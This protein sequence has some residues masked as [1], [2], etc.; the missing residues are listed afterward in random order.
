MNS[1]KMDVKTYER[2]VR[3]EREIKQK[4]EGQEK[5]EKKKEG[6]LQEPKGEEY[7]QEYEQRT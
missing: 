7:K 4:E 6:Q 3:R 1:G 2:R 5:Q